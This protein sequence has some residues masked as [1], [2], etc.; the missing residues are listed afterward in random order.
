MLVL[1]A[2]MLA[3]CAPRGET[4]TRPFP[5]VSVPSVLDGAERGEYVISHYWNKFLGTE[6]LFPS[7]DSSIINGVTRENV[8]QAAADFAGII[9]GAPLSLTDRVMKNLATRLCDYCAVDTASNALKE[10]PSILE[11]YFYNPN[12]PLRDEDIFG[13]FAEKLSGSPLLDSASRAS[14]ADIARRAGLNR[15]G[16]TAADFRFLDKK[17]RR[18]SL[19]GIRAEYIILFFSNPGCTACKEIIDALN[20]SEEIRSLIAGGHI[21]VLN[22]YIDEELDEWYKYLH[23]YPDEWYNGYDDNHI[24]RDDELYDVRAIPSLYLLG[25]DKTVIMKDVPTE[26]MMQFI[27]GIIS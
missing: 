7:R 1:A 5:A 14:Y 26:R 2:L 17:G 11:K 24:I 3:S 23:V 21:A 13:P 10:F 6:N 12:S 27:A 8:E 15:R 22:I 9:S 20:T 19:Y 4:L 16:S 18:H 25:A